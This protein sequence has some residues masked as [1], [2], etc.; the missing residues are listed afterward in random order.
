[1]Q[2]DGLN[3]QE[4]VFWPE[5]P[6]QL[7]LHDHWQM[8]ITFWS[9]QALH[10]LSNL[11]AQSAINMFDCP[12]IPKLLHFS[13]AACQTSFTSRNY[14]C[15]LKASQQKAKATLWTCSG[16]FEWCVSHT[17]VPSIQ[18]KEMSVQNLL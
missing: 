1:M 5:L 6:V 18:S 3:V 14:T 2:L 10:E 8:P 11:E 15:L 4:M 12:Y 9:W 17:Q 16:F 7:V 13:L